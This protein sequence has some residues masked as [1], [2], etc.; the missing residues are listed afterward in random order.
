MMSLEQLISVSEKLVVEAAKT[1][2]DL[3]ATA[4]AAYRYAG[5]DGNP[6]KEWRKKARQSAAL[7][8]LSLSVDTG[9]LNRA[10]FNVQ[11]SISVNSTGVTVGPA[12]NNSNQYLTNQTMF[13]AKAVWSLSDVIFHRQTLAMER[14]NRNRIADRQKLLDQINQLYHERIRLKAAILSRRQNAHAESAEQAAL[15]A[16]LMQ[17]T[18]ELNL[19]TGGWFSENLNGEGHV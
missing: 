14:E 1:E 13:T 4:Q 7:P 15:Q 17:V 6:V 16:A 10:N 3:M 8:S 18:G 2:P 5:L 9:Y 19:L 12:A 11:D